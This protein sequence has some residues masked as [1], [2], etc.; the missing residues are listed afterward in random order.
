MSIE[1]D[2]LNPLGRRGLIAS[3]NLAVTGLVAI[4][5]TTKIVV[6]GT[7]YIPVPALIVIF[8]GL[9]NAVYLRRNGS[10]DIAAWVLVILMLWGLTF[11][12][13]NM[14][15]FDAA[16]V[17]LSPIIPIL[18]MLIIG[19]R[20]AIISL[21]LV[22][23]ILSALFV[24]G[25]N[26]LLPENP[27]GRNEILFAR[28]LVL[29]SLCFISTWVVWRFTTI[30]KALLVKLDKQS[31][32]DYLTRVLN[33]RAIESTLVKEVGRARRSKTWLSFIMADVDLFKLYNDSN[34]HQMGDHCLVDITNVIT[35]CCERTSDVVGRFGG[36]E[37]VLILPDT[38]SE[39]ARQV[40]ESIRR[41]LLAK[42]IPYGPENPDFV[43]LTL[44]VVSAL[45]V[46][47]ENNDQLIKLA[48]AAL[49]RGKDQGRNC[50]VSHT[51]TDEIIDG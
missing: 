38:D 16:L 6:M 22:Y 34:G 3:S 13:Y 48:D 12:G 47:I 42:K 19:S 18:T 11:G 36:E 21:G 28:F 23:L 39:G 4:L 51:L 45:G 49:Y 25:F 50:V 31:N 24:L 40:A 27:N 5:A 2:N 14:G 15:G 35:S 33:R 29:I 46:D 26:G 20:A 32:T 8:V 10:M 17:L 30:S 9:A 1:S 44:G 37:F 41:K 43:S 7:A